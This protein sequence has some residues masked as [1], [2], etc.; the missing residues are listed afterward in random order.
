MK[1]VQTLTNS[2]VHTPIQLHTELRRSGIATASTSGVELRANSLTTVNNSAI[3]NINFADY[4]P[5]AAKELS[6]SADP[7]DYI[8][9]PVIIMLSDLPNRNGVGF[10]LKELV[11]WNIERGCQAHKTWLGQPLCEEHNNAV[12][13]GKDPAYGIIVDSYLSPMLGFANDKIWKLTIMLALDRTKK[14]EL[15]RR[16]LDGSL[17]TV[18][19]GAWTSSYLCSYCTKEIGLC[20]HLN[21]KAAFDFYSYR[22]PDN[23]DHIISRLCTN[24]VGLE[25]SLVSTPAYTQAV[26]DRKWFNQY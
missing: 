18:S 5:F 2:A 10:P 16:V 6:I 9:W 19:M 26:F 15:T 3:L 11:K 8:L 4:L 12:L 22:A 24:P 1:I 21:P 25:T 20:D 14:P 13:E 17:N 7:K 23:S